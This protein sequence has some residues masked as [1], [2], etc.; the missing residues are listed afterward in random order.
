ME[1]Y[2]LTVSQ[3]REIALKE[4]LGVGAVLLGQWEDVTGTVFHLRR[5]LTAGERKD[6]GEAL[7]IRGTDEAE[8]RWLA[9]QRF[10]PLGYKDWKG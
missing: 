8:R 4:L 9:V 3:A 6:I 2:A 1:G 7:D 10:L 5:R